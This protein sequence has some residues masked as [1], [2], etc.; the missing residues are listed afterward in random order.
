M[1]HNLHSNDIAE[2]LK[3]DV[4][5]KFLHKCVNHKTYLSFLEQI[6]V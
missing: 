5:P 4:N 3:W 1:V 2:K 6:V